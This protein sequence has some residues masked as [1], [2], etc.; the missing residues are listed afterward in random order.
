VLGVVDEPPE[1][2]DPLE[3]PMFGQ[4]TLEPVC[5]LGVPVPP[6]GVVVLGADDG[7]GLAAETAATPPPTR[8]SPETTAVRT[9]RRRPLGLVSTVAGST[10]EGCAGSSGWYVHSMTSPC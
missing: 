5:V 3:P 2:P 1:L 8:S 10:G 7:A 4:F 6:E 9:A